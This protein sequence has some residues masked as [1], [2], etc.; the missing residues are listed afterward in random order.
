MS[1]FKTKGFKIAAI[2]SGCI[3]VLCLMVFELGYNEVTNIIKEFEK[4]FKLVSETDE[5]KNLIVELKK[6]E[7]AGAGC[8]KQYKVFTIIKLNHK[9]NRQQFLEI[10]EYKKN[11][12]VEMALSNINQIKSFVIELS[13]FSNIVK[14]D[15]FLAKI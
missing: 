11:S 2:V 15:T 1:F 13:K 9:I 5:Y 7:I 4:D 8:G 12:E 10:F 3:I 14:N 6:T